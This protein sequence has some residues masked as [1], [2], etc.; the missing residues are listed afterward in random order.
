MPNRML[1]QSLS[2]KKQLTELRRTFHKYPELGYEETNTARRVTER[3]QDLGLTVSRPGG[4]A[5]VASIKGGRPGKV[6][7]LRSDMDALAVQEVPGREYGS[8]TPGVMHACGHDGHMTMLLGTAHLLKEIQEELRGEVRLVFQ[9]AEE[10]LP[11]GGAKALVEAGVLDNPPAD[12]ALGVH[13]WPDLPS[14]QVGVVSGPVMAAADLFEAT[15]RGRGGHGAKPH[16]SDNVILCSAQ[17]VVALHHLVARTVEASAPA[18]LSVGTFHGGHSPNVIPDEATISG[19]VRYFDESAGRNLRKGI[20]EISSRIAG[21]YHCQAHV[22]YRPGYP[23]VVNDEAAVDL[24][25]LAVNEVLGSGALVRDLRPAMV[26]EDFSFFGQRVPSCYFW[27]GTQNKRKGT[28]HPLHSPDFDLDEDV[29]PIGSA[30]LAQ[31]CADF[32]A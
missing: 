17:T 31:A 32:L 6:I 4:P 22:Q 24:L 8:R 23:A 2:L 3:L 18:V 11:E 30:I 20:E 26:S 10:R 16:Q 5:V 28:H 12:L 25:S 7:V 14:G 29:L 19:T 27:L 15:C 9:P 21:V 1:Q 13:L